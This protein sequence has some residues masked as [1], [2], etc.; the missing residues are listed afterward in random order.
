MLCC[1]GAIINQPG[2]D[3]NVGA[4]DGPDGRVRW[5]VRR[6]FRSCGKDRPARTANGLMSSVVNRAV[7]EADTAAFELGFDFQPELY[8]DPRRRRILQREHGDEPVR[9]G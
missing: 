7:Q 9:P 4:P 5:K 6:G 3:I 8:H 1:S 2:T